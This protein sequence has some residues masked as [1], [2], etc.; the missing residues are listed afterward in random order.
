MRKLSI[1]C[2]VLLLLSSFSSAVFADQ[3]LANQNNAS[4]NNESEQDVNS[5]EQEAINEGEQ[6]LKPPD[7]DINSENESAS[8]NESILDES[9]QN[10]RSEQTNN[11]DENIVEK[12]NNIDSHAVKNEENEEQQE[13]DETVKETVENKSSIKMGSFSISQTADSNVVNETATSKLGHIKTRSVKIY[14]NLNDFTQSF[15]AGE[16]YTNRVYYIKKQA[17]VNGEQFYLLSL[18]AS[19]TIGVV[20]WAKASDISSHD[21]KTIDSRSK[22]LYIKGTGSAYSKAWGGKKDL[23]Y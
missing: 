11:I 5:M 2:I 13:K 16:E 9:Q 6:D 8:N 17:S 4:I 21:H 20:G 22:L 12:S 18:R 19:S 3:S 23:V 14:K 7:Q 1:S 10:I 15:E